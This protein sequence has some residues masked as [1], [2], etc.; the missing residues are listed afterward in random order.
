MRRTGE[1]LS[2]Y[3]CTYSTD[4][5]IHVHVVTNHIELAMND[6]FVGI[7]GTRSHTLNS[8]HTWRL[9]KASTCIAK[10]HVIVVS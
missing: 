6:L 5:Y 3:T 10:V 9:V 8:S 4:G 7:V 2:R 1:S